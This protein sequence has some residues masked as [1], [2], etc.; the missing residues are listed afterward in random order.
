M[1]THDFDE[2]HGFSL[3]GLP[4]QMVAIKAHTKATSIRKGSRE[5]DITGIDC[6][7]TMPNGREFTVDIKGRDK[8][9]EFFRTDSY[10]RLI[11]EFTIEIRDRCPRKELRL[12]IHGWAVS[13]TKKCDQIA[14]TFDEDLGG[15][16]RLYLKDFYPL[17]A[18][19]LRHLDEWIATY[20]VR[21]A[22]T[23]KDI[24]GRVLPEPYFT[25]NIFVPGPVLDAAIA[26][27]SAGP[28]VPDFPNPESDELFNAA[29]YRARVIKPEVNDRPI[30]SDLFRKK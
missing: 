19:T 18:A 9:K 3:R 10:G 14:Y 27:A 17:R 21:W 15:L 6:A 28:T 11:V 1:A 24:Y 2:R 23:R 8:A 13:P 12:G 4:A 5:E 16:P 30:Q 20:K 7:Y 22:Q 26:E 29:R 25:A